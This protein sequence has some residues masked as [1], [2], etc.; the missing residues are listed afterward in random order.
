LENSMFAAIMIARKRGVDEDVISEAEVVVS[1]LRERLHAEV[2]DALEASLNSKDLEAMEAAITDADLVDFS[3]PLLDSV[4]TQFTTL[5]S[6]QARK[7]LLVRLGDGIRLRNAEALQRV[8]NAASG[9]GMQNEPSFLL[10]ADVL[11]LLQEKAS[12]VEAGTVR[13]SRDQLEEALEKNRL[14]L[15]EAA[16]KALQSL[17]ANRRRSIEIVK[18]HTEDEDED[19]VLEANDEVRVGYRFCCMRDEM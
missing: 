1:A 11:K 17:N 15:G 7:R 14:E 16:N 9:L 6:E 10:A 19:D 2:A 4:R 8:I 3:G 18:V 13:Q 12:I 5:R